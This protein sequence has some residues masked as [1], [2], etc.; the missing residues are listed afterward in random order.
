MFV[1]QGTTFQV[2]DIAIPA[3]PV[4]VSSVTVPGV[5][6]DIALNGNYAVVAANDAGV[7]IVDISLPATPRLRG[8]YGTSGAA[9]AVKLL[10][11][12]AYV[13]DEI[14]GLVILD[15]TNPDAPTSLSS[16]D[17][18]ALAY[19]VAL[20]NTVAGLFAIVAAEDR[21]LIVDVSNPQSPSKLS[22]VAVGAYNF[23][24]A[25]AGNLAFLGHTANG[26]ATV[27]I[28]NLSNPVSLGTILEVNNSYVTVVAMGNTVVLGGTAFQLV[29][30]SGIGT[31][32]RGYL[33]L[34][35]F[36]MEHYGAF[37]MVI[38]NG[39]AWAA[40]G[41][42]VFGV[43]IAN[44]DAPQLIF[45]KDD[46]GG[47]FDK[48]VSFGPNIA[49]TA[50]GK[51]V[52]YNAS[53]NDLS[54]TAVP[55]GATYPRGFF[56]YGNTL[57]D[58]DSA[59]FANVD[60]GRS[61]LVL[62]YQ[63]Q[64]IGNL[65][66]LTPLT[67]NMQPRCAYY[68]GSRILSVCDT[69]NFPTLNRYTVIT[70]HDPSGVNWIL[71]QKQLPTANLQ[72][73]LIAGAQEFFFLARVDFSVSPSQGILES[74]NW[75]GSTPTWQIS[76]LKNT[77]ALQLSDNNRYLH[78]G[79]YPRY[80]IYDVA[81][82]SNPI[83]LSTTAT[84]AAVF[85]ILIENHYA[86]LACGSQGVLVY[87]IAD[88]RQ[89][90]LVRSYDTPGGAFSLTKI[91]NRLFVADYQAG[92][93]VLGLTDIEPPQVFITA[94]VALPQFQ[95]TNSTLT[96]GG[97]AA[98]DSGQVSRVIWSNDRGGGGVAQGT[99]DWLVSAVT[100]QPG[101]NVLT[102]T[103]F[104]AEG[105]A[106]TDQIT[107]LSTPADTT[108]PV[109]TITG[110]RPDAEFAV[111][112]NVITLS[113][114]AADN[115]SVT[116]L[117]WRNDRG[118]AGT[119]TLAGQGWSVPNLLLAPGPNRLQVT[120]TDA[121]GNM[122]SNA[123]VIFYVPADTNAPVISIDF[124]TLNAVYDTEA[125]TLNLSGM[126]TDNSAVTKVEWSNDRGGHGLAD[127]SAP[128]SVNGILLQPGL[129]VLTVTATDDAGNT[130]ADTLS[131]TYTLPRPGLALARAGDSLV[132]LWPTNTPGYVL[133]Y[134]TNLLAASWATNSTPPVVTS[135]NYLITAPISGSRM[136]YR[137]R[138]W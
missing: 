73:D 82:P 134:A 128:W 57:F 118:G 21:M 41:T 17:L 102:V 90:K 114:S 22:E 105:N 87:D 109:I 60:G 88:K 68:N 66:Q 23:S 36:A 130:A 91:G 33:D 110:P 79:D 30:V 14:G 3:S 125:D 48:V 65:T 115:Q 8:S 7:Q 4:L 12:R 111:G 63:M 122:A 20:K 78:V 104:D 46:Q 108:A 132:F 61:S 84:T 127:G 37:R 11:G 27:D 99:T 76:D 71:R 29:D 52:A 116:N 16:L 70:E 40:G 32:P 59:E 117:T 67:M 34:Y 137:L 95:T 9:Y 112:T 72:V 39:I 47:R 106:G 80:R 93:Q 74:Y 103:A 129:N 69:N 96:L 54:L 10:A 51:V 64:P 56:F 53:G 100:L 2:Y 123:A 31:T 124:P 113:G 97:G 42:A 120:A 119:M 85:A 5:I 58:F 101:T 49:A 6:Q 83:P 136:F 77:G 133:E 138:K 15:V 45:R 94:P 107:I 81:D 13:A 98:D 1:G 50:G 35:P 62:R 24:V 44:P 38:Q 26:I 135:G 92:I 86:Y 89:P 131:V 75:S 126:A 18:G 28:S 19:D 43:N 25:L 55:A 121:S